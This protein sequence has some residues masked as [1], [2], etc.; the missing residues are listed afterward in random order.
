[1]LL[2]WR[3]KDPAR[4]GQNGSGRSSYGEKKLV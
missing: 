4:M 2:S 3:P 1:M